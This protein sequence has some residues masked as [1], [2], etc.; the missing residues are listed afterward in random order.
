MHLGNHEEA[1]QTAHWAV[2]LQPKF[3]AAASFRQRVFPF[4]NQ[5]RAAEGN[6]RVR[7]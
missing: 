2:R 4:A 6:R 3:W 7:A 5:M 1:L